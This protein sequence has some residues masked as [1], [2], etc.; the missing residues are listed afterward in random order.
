MAASQMC[1]LTLH[2]ALPISK[3]GA[4]GWPGPRKRRVA[5]LTGVFDPCRLARQGSN[6]PVRFAI[7][8][9]STTHP[10]ANLTDRKSTRL[11][12]SHAGIAYAVLRLNKKIEQ[13]PG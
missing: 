12:S 10:R 2:V 5:N 1:T 8:V 11:N 13:H 9:F 7:V 3:Q 6:T 4:A